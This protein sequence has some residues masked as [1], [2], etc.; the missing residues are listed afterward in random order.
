M[1]RPTPPAPPPSRDANPFATCW[2]RP[3]ALPWSALER[4]DPH[5]IVRALLTGGG[6]GQV[7]GPHGAGKSSLLAALELPL[8]EAGRRP[9]LFEAIAGGPEPTERR[10]VLLV[11]GFERLAP[12]EQRERLATWSAAPSSF[13][14][15]THRSI[16]GGPTPIV[17]LAKL[18]PTRRLF[19]AL[20]D[21]LTRERP[22]AVSRAEAVAR[23]RR[24]RGDLRE[25]WFDL[26]NLHE[27]RARGSACV[28]RTA[29]VVRTYTTANAGGTAR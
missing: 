27:A 17:V 3:G 12:R 26:Y 7:V 20:F 15:T 5:A 11:E 22:T 1:I 8:L 21:E 19:E 16:D 2:T 25:T 13:I 6:R 10:D 24:R 9:V 18:R 29:P 28:P 14:V 4:V 23:W